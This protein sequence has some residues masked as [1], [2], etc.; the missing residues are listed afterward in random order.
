MLFVQ[1]PCDQKH[2][3]IAPT[4]TRPAAANSDLYS[5]LTEKTRS[6]RFTSHYILAFRIIHAPG[7]G[8]RKAGRIA[9]EQIK[10]GGVRFGAFAQQRVDVLGGCGGRTHAR[11][12]ETESEE[13]EGAEREERA[14]RESIESKE[15]DREQ[16][17]RSDR[18][19]RQERPE[20]PERGFGC[21]CIK[22]QRGQMI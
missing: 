18:P 2:K 13:R 9:R 11:L 22:V 10:G 12:H 8:A 15:I 17:E 19:D 16:R 7:I 5:R 6:T 3:L 20:R 4:T 14:D 1:T 21:G